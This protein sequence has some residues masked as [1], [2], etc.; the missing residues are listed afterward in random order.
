MGVLGLEDVAE[1]GGW[2]SAGRSSAQLWLGSF[3]DFFKV[4]HSAWWESGE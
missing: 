4:R 1:P 2:G 3:G